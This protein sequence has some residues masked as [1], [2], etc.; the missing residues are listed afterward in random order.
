MPSN[1]LRRMVGALLLANPISLCAQFESLSQCIEVSN[2]GATVLRRR[3]IKARALP[4]AVV[5]RAGGRCVSAGTSQRVVYDR[6]LKCPDGLLLPSFEEWAAKNTQAPKDPFPIH[7]VVEA[8][9]AGDR[10]IIDLTLGQLRRSSGADLP[11][12]VVS[13]GEGWPAYSLADGTQVTYLAC[14]YPEK[15]PAGCRRYKNK[16]AEEGLG[17]LM[18]LALE[19]DLDHDRFLAELARLSPKEHQRATKRLEEWMGPVPV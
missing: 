14:P 4:C 7:M 19:C 6:L 10:A 2:C 16:T 3:N 5:V 18:N 15:I 11:L 9:I 12:H 1:H 17:R 13:Y 8:K